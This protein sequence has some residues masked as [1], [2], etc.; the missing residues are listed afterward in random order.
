MKK[1]EFNCKTV[2]QAPDDS[3]KKK[4][5]IIVPVEIRFSDTDANGHVFF[6]NYFTLFD[7]AFLKFLKIID[8]SFERFL[9]NNLNF[10]YVEAK[11]LYKSPVKFDDELFIKVYAGHLGKTSF[12][13]KFEAMNK[14]SDKIAAFGH[15]VAVVVDLRTEKPSALPDEFIEVLGQFGS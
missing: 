3:V 12:T 8:Y 11:S 13:I 9:D 15:I 14:T 7:S 6:G 2:P 10:Y 1:T 5:P 4:D